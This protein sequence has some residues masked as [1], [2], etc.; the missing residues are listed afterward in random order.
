M[1]PLLSLIKGRLTK[2]RRQRPRA[3]MLLSAFCLLLFVFLVLSAVHS[4]QATA[5]VNPHGNF[6][7]QTALCSICHRLTSP[8]QSS[9]VQQTNAEVCLTCHQDVRGHVPENQCSNCHDPHGKTDNLAMIRTVIQE[10]PV[11]FR[12][13]IGKDSFADG[14]SKA[15]LCD[16]CHT[17]TKYHSSTATLTHFEAQD[18]TLCHPHRIGFQPDPPC[19]SCHSLRPDSGAH[20]VHRDVKRGPML[21]DDCDACHWEVNTWVGHITGQVEF[22]DKKTLDETGA[23]N[24]CHSATG[25]ANAK[26]QWYAGG[27]VACLDCHSAS[28][29]GNTQANDKGIDAPAVDRYWTTSGHGNASQ[30]QPS[31]NPGAKLA[32]ETCHD[33][34]SRHFSNK[35]GDSNRLRGDAN[36]LCEN[37][38]IAGNGASVK[39]STHGNLDYSTRKQGKFEVACTECHNPHGT[40]NLFMV[41]QQIG[42]NDIRF[43]ALT[44]AGSFDES[45]PSASNKNDLCATCHR[46]TAH[47]R[48]T[49][50]ES[51]NPHHEGEE[52]TRCHPHDPDGKPTTVDG[53]M[54]ATGCDVCHGQP[55]PPAAAGYP[56]FNENKT[57]HRI[58]AGKGDGQY[59]YACQKCHANFPAEHLTSPATWQSV[60]FDDFNPGASYD[61]GKFTC[62]NLYCHSNGDPRGSQIQYKNPTWGENKQLD[63][64]GC[65]RGESISTGSHATHLRAQ[66]SD[67]GNTS[68]GCYE[69]HAKTAKDGNNNAIADTSRHVDGEKQVK[70]DEKD[71]MGRSSDADFDP[72]DGSCANSLCHSDGAASRET[73]G[74]PRFASPVWGRSSTGACGTCHSYT[75]AELGGRHQAHF[76]LGIVDCITCHTNESDPTHVDGRVEF[77]DG[78]T[79]SGTGVCD[80]CHGGGGAVNGAAEAKSKWYT[81]EALS[82]VGCHDNG[83]AEFN[84]R[85]AG[86]VYGDNNDYGFNYSGHG[87][88]GV[89]CEDCHDLSK[90]HFDAPDYSADQ[91]NFTAAFRLQDG[92]QQVPRRSGDVYNAG[93]FGVC[94][95]CHDET[96][97]VGMPED[98]S[99]ALFTHTNPPPDGYPKRGPAVTGFRNELD[100]GFNLGNV[101][102]N[103]H[104][105]HLDMNQVNWD[106]DGNGSKDSLPTCL[107]CHDPHGVRSHADGR[108]YPAMTYADMGIKH[109]Q[110]DNGE[111]GE[112]T[113]DDY[114]RRCNTC[115]PGTGL[116]YY[117][118]D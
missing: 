102:A 36:A 54:L 3:R 51:S 109:D 65:H 100:A 74:T 64:S 27:R 53:F 14:V 118:P 111:F 76:A 40:A 17:T 63:C 113:R 13:T 39:V 112:V 12:G 116:K 61:R 115:H 41:N 86:N 92:V 87:L 106:S 11:R 110:D 30:Y 88:F 37:C 42:G 108:N 93:Q 83:P 56:N 25:A 33:P 105:D 103:A 35:L 28:H 38:H 34:D 101:P 104:W 66:Y 5:V 32:C 80:T 20:K 78:K 44:G 114:N 10:K 52:C 75:P 4:S 79:L 81:T 67:R 1:T 82:C 46:N 85:Q 22:S 71:V 15:A 98:Y 97:L 57:P 84:G 8:F 62:N 72:S 19:G 7:T 2:N 16:V 117:R 43:T 24:N 69:C 90:P 96:R 91:N 50:V 68:I 31:G 47:N 99:N 58:H 107:T 48:V 21:G 73:P 26:A 29:P 18:C 89:F 59:A 6:T 55:P 94:F 45:N 70:I 49:N 9:L 60:V 77:K 95:R 23:C